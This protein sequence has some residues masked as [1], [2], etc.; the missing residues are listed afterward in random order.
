MRDAAGELADRLHLL[1]LGELLLQLA[2]LGR[3]ERIDDRALLAGVLGGRRRRSAPSASP[4]ALFL[5]ATTL[6]GWTSPAAVDARPAIGL[7]QAARSRSPS[8]A[9]T[10][11][12]L[13]SP[14]RLQRLRQQLREGGVGVE[15]A[16]FAVERRRSPSA[17]N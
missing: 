11:Q 15:N 5:E 10:D 7:A 13:A 14:A 1:R 2:M 3:V 9:S 12:A 17:S 6:T 16:T 8:P 4:A